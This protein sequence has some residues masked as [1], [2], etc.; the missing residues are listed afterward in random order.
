MKYRALLIALL[1]TLGA[2]SDDTSAP[3]TTVTTPNTTA[4]TA[5][6]GTTA[7]PTT[8]GTPATTSPSTTTGRQITGDMRSH[9]G[10]W[11]SVDV[12]HWSILLRGFDV[13][14]GPD[15]ANLTI[16][17]MWEMI[18]GVIILTGVA[19][20]G[21]DC[22]DIEGRYRPELSAEY[23]TLTLIED[24]CEERA[25]WMRGTYRMDRP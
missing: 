6:P 12:S 9:E 25:D 18:D 3:A 14:A 23:M 13:L 1:L 21:A 20:E 10:Y 24:A 11:T 8:A 15:P 17:G 19:V 4:T 7:A 16:P 22:G 5:A 2:C